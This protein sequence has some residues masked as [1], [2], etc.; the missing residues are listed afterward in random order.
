MKRLLAVLAALGVMVGVGSSA[1]CASPDFVDLCRHDFFTAEI[2]VPAGQ[3]HTSAQYDVGEDGKA[4]FLIVNYET[5]SKGRLRTLVNYYIETGYELYSVTLDGEN[6]WDARIHE[7]YIVLDEDASVDHT[8]QVTYRNIC[9]SN[10]VIPLRYAFYSALYPTDWFHDC[11]NWGISNGLEDILINS[12][13]AAIT[14]GQ[15]AMYIRIMKRV[16]NEH[17]LTAEEQDIVDTECAGMSLDDAKT[18]L[19]QIDEEWCQK[20]YVNEYPQ[21][22]VWQRSELIYVTK[23]GYMEGEPAANGLLKFRPYD[24]MTRAEMMTVLY[25]VMG[26]PEYG[27]LTEEQ[28]AKTEDAADWALAALG[29]FLSVDAIH[30]NENGDLDLDGTV[31]RAEALQFIYNLCKTEDTREEQ[32]KLFPNIVY[33]E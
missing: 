3:E 1:M 18:Y 13:Q 17:G 27:P 11:V 12:P 32:N 26:E 21:T 30:G 10:Q 28:A 29:Y 33:S 20:R 9:Y 25:R 24:S 19:T 7:R 16:V 4:G 31:T 8:I 2:Y 14:R 5:L 15:F 22:S 23:S 6:V